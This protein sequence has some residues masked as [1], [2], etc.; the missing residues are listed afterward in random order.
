[1]RE[2]RDLYQ[3]MI[4][5]HNKNPKNF[6]EIDSA[7]NTAEG[8][9]PLC[10]DHYWVYLKIADNEIEEIKFR[11]DGC[12]ISKASASMMT[13]LLKGQTVEQAQKMFTTFKEVTSG[14]F[15][16]DISALGTMS[17]FRGVGAFP[18]RVKCAN[19]AWHTMK[20]ALASEKEKAEYVTTE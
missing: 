16:K 9:N 4:L 15:N 20:A 7:T 14:N 2:L 17:I 10:G 19:L 5:D 6:G 18:N 12:A 13:T 11:G 1:M 8:Y 3:Q